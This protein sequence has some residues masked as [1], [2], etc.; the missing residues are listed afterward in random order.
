MWPANIRDG[1]TARF[2]PIRTR[3]QPVAAGIRRGLIS[4][5]LSLSRICLVDDDHARKGRV[6]GE[7]QDEKPGRLQPTAWAL[8]RGSA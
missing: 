7:L 2:R 3:A 5:M 8:S 4:G 1:Q 6:V